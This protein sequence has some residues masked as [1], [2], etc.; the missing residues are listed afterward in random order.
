MSHHI[1]ELIEHGLSRVHSHRHVLIREAEFAPTDQVGVFVVFGKCTKL[2][3]LL[4]RSG[5]VARCFFKVSWR[6]EFL[7]AFPTK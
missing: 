4:L 5:L 7:L 3:D 2:V 6:M 1:V